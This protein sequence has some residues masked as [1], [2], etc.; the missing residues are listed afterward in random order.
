MNYE[1]LKQLERKEYNELMELYEIK[2]AWEER[3]ESKE[4]IESVEHS[5]T[6]QHGRWGML[7]DIIEQLENN[8]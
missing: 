2:T 8:K 3:G 6:W 1:Q 4:K 5:I 7:T